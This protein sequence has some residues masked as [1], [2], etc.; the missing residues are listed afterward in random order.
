MNPKRILMFA[1][2]TAILTSA[3][4]VTSSALAASSC[5]TSVTVV[6]GDTLRKIADRCGT[7]VSALRRANPEI[8]SGNLIYPGQVLQLPGAILGT[9]GGY[10]IYIVARGDTLKGLATRF[11]TTIDV[12][13]SGNPEITNPNVIYEGQWIK[14]YV[15]PTTPPPATPPAGP[16]EIYHVKTD[17]TL[18]K[19]AEKFGTTVDVLLQLNAG[20][21]NPNL[22]YVGQAIK[23]PAAA[24]SHI[25]QKGDTLRI[26]A[27]QYGTTVDALLKLNPDIKNPNL[28]Y[29]GQIIKIK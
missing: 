27:A 28:I 2:L 24:T 3:L 6:Q 18:R 1:L 23:V 5:G 22:I 14:V 12:L 8:G 10:F 9:D 15:A 17:D 25:V 21:A 13:L 19:I 4:F 29:V 26:I 11:Y 20:I 7:T 16:S